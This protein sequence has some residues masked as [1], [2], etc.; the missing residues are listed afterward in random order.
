MNII[1]TDR[2]LMLDCD[3][4]LPHSLHARPSA[5]IAQKARE[6]ESNILI[7]ADT[8]EADAKSMLDILSL[9]LQVNATVRLLANGPD[10]FAALLALGRLLLG[11]NL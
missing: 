1:S 8:G 6:F 7:I 3:L 11:E 9:A 4:K 5:R 2:G 10:A